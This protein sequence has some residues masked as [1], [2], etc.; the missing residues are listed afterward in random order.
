MRESQ[1]SKHSVPADLRSRR[2]DQP[3]PGSD[4]SVYDTAHLFP[5]GCHE[6]RPYYEWVEES[7]PVQTAPMGT[8]EEAFFRGASW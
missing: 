6:P 4:R 3:L 8:K 2:D 7:L 5:F 1:T